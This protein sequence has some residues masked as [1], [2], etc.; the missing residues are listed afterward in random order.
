MRASIAAALRSRAAPS[1]E[2][3]AASGVLADLPTAGAL[4]SQERAWSH[5][6]PRM[7]AMYLARKHTA[8]TYTE[9]G[10]FFGGRNHSTAVAAEKKVRQWLRDD[11][12]LTLGPRRLP[13]REIFERVERELLR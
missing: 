12:V 7:V 10:Q 3:V 5:A 9:V 2:A 13:V 8:C 6:H 4:Q 1:A 11:G